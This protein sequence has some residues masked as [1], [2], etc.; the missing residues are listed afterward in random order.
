MITAASVFLGLVA[1]CHSGEGPKINDPRID[2]VDQAIPCVDT[3]ED[4]LAP[5]VLRYHSKD[6][7]CADGPC[8]GLVLETKFGW[9][10]K[11]FNLSKWRPALGSTLE[12]FLRTGDRYDPD[13]FDLARKLWERHT[14][15]DG[16][17]RSVRAL[18]N[19]IEEIDP[20]EASTTIAPVVDVTLGRIA[21]GEQPVIG[22]GLN[23]VQHAKD[24]G[25]GDVR[26]FAKYVE[27]TGAYAPLELDGD[28]PLLDYE[29]ELGIVLLD[30]INLRNIPV[31]S[32]LAARTALFVAN[33][34]TDRVPVIE[35]TRARLTIGKSKPG[36]LPAGPWMVRASELQGDVS[37]FPK[38]RMA[39]EVFEGAQGAT[40]CRQT[41]STGEMRSVPEL[42]FSRLAQWV[43]EHGPIVSLPDGDHGLP[44]RIPLVQSQPVTVGSEEWI[45]PK[46]TIIV[47][48][49][50]AGTAFTAP[51]GSDKLGLVLEAISRAS[52]SPRAVLVEHLKENRTAEGYLS[53]G[54]KVRAGIEALGIQEFAIKN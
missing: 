40:T 30:D 17:L 2:A 41:A 24:A 22:V 54:D 48:G 39:L 43:R 53:S 33:D 15:T 44:S 37:K 42:L 52:F 47:T 1:G 13:G 23:Y 46:G 4:R 10:T 29:V 16:G 5:R 50:P 8:F 12:S 45:L 7:S 11:V 25:G 38:L 3:I 32:V 31:A 6:M 14:T 35:Y 19:W 28:V 27:P 34:L 21:A 18:R 20:A 26:F 36:F 49:T 9:P 51:D